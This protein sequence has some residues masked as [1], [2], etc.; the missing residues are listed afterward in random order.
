MD[1]ESPES[2]TLYTSLYPFIAPF[3]LPLGTGFHSTTMNQE[4]LRT[5]LKFIGGELGTRGLDTM[6]VTVINELLDLKK[7]V[8]FLLVRDK[9]TAFGSSCCNSFTFRSFSCLIQCRNTNDVQ[10]ENTKV[11]NVVLDWII[12][13]ICI[14]VA[15]RLSSQADINLVHLDLSKTMFLG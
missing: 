7:W 9:L 14:D 13:E 15:F 11:T 8:H 12:R 3:S 5:K 6:H 4:S 1:I 10:C 2:F